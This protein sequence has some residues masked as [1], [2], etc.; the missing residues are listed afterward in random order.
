ML[1]A[2][3]ATTASAARVCQQSHGVQLLATR[4][5]PRGT[6]P[7]ERA[8]SLHLP[9][10]HWTVNRPPERR[11]LLPAI[12]LVDETRLRRPH[13][14]GR[15]ERAEGEKCATLD[16]H[17]SIE[18]LRML[19]LVCQCVLNREKVATLGFKHGPQHNCCRGPDLHRPSVTFLL[20]GGLLCCVAAVGDR[21]DAHLHA[22]RKGPS[23]QLRPP[24]LQASRHQ[25]HGNLGG[26]HAHQRLPRPTTSTMPLPLRLLWRLSVR[27]FVVESPIHSIAHRWWCE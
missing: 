8:S 4:A 21:A 25:R 5:R 2:P 22:S 10:L 27:S 17:A 7:P 13:K 3:A 16:A 11:R 1:R 6:G 14:R 26:Q 18:W 9:V 20:S 19:V 15:T 24:W 12:R 23:R